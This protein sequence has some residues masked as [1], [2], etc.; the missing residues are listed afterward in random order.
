MSKIRLYQSLPRSITRRGF[1]LRIGGGIATTLFARRSSQAQGAA[2]F[3]VALVPDPQYLAADASCS[4]SSAYNALIQWGITNKNLLVN[5]APLNIKGFL[6]VGD[7]VDATSDSVYSTPQ[8][9]SVNAYAQAERANMFVARTC[10]N[11]DYSNAG[12]INRNQIGY[13]WRE[14]KSGAWSP[15]NVA[16]IYSGGMDLGNGDVAFFGG[17][18]Q[19]PTFPISTANAW[20]R[21][22]IQGRKIIVAS[23]EHY[24]RSAV[25]AYFKGIHDANPDHEFWFLTHG[26]MTTAGERVDRG[27]TYGP[28]NAGLA[29]APAS[30]SGL[31]MWSGSSGNAGLV[32][33][34]NLTFVGCGHWIDGYASPSSTNWV[35]QRLEDASASV[36]GQKVQQVFCDCQTADQT[37]FCSG[38]GNPNGKADVM[39]LMLLRIFPTTGMMD[40]Y[41][42]S[43]NNNT[44]T[45]G[46]GVRGLPGPTS[47]GAQ[48]FN[49]NFPGLGP[50]PPASGPRII[51]VN[52][53]GG[54][55]DIAQ[56][57]WIEI[58]GA[59][60]APAGVGPNGVTWGSAPEFASG[61]MP[62]QLSSVSV[63]VNGKPAFVYFVS[64]AQIN[65]LTPLDNSVGP[66]QI[67]VKSGNAAAAPFTSTL[68]AT[69]PSFPRLGASNYIAATHADGSLLGPA[70]MSVPGYTFAPA[71]PGETIILYAV[72]FGM[73]V[74]ALVNG[75]AAQTGSLPAMPIILIG[76]VAA[77][78]Q[79]AGVVSPG[80]Y[81]LNVVVPINLV[82]GDNAVTAIY[83]G[84]ETPAGS[85]IAVQ[86]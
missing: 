79:F 24:P 18:Y 22:R 81:Q 45:G 56:N 15:T 47:A 3:T 61:N 53:A 50:L 63:T 66:V 78:V 38:S 40:A 30:N 69:A 5:G 35:W 41:L 39:H 31:E 14:D 84:F 67:V 16:A 76:G 68:R 80:L 8:T 73:P 51:A 23:A 11:H 4:G 65:V 77:S 17:A 48:L 52:T 43:T 6:Q 27:D 62:T 10:G 19:D 71:R 86:R 57:D 26:Y 13:M 32:T 20:M 42:V 46:P 12:S 1:N 2:P 54:F 36:R 28:N 70:S 83:S 60:L 72:G 82:N 7:C 21:L 59:N 55:P 34:P 25:M 9:Y 58:K 75:S 49:I 85:A 74:T 33:W 37:N 29:A 64:P 44:W